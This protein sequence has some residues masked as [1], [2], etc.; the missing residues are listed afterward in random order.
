MEQKYGKYEV[1]RKIGQGGFGVVYEGRDPFIKRRVAIKTCSAEDEDMRRRFFREAEIVGTL[2]HR[3][4]VT[5]FDL[6]QQDGVPY[7]VQEYLT[8]EDLAHKIKRRDLIDDYT[9]LSYLVQVAEGLEY[10]HAQGVVH[11]DIKPAN[12]RILEDGSVKIMD[13]GIAKLASAETQLTHTGMAM[14]TAGYLPPEQIRGEKVDLRAD[15]FSYGVMS[16]ELLAGQRPFVAD[17]MSAVLFQIIGQEPAPLS[18]LWPQCPPALERLVRKSLAKNPSERYA[19]FTPLLADLRPLREQVRGHAAPVAPAPEMAT[20]VILSAQT[21]VELETLRGLEKR[22]REAVEKGDLTAAELEL[23][24]AKKRHGD[25]ATF[26]QV[27]DPLMARIAEIRKAWEEDRQRSER[28]AGLV[29]RART[30]R[31]EQNLGEA[32]LALTAA[33]D[34][35]PENQEVQSL[36]RTVDEAIEKKQYEARETEGARGAATKVEGLLREG[37][38]ERAEEALAEALHRHGGREPLPA[39]QKLVQ[40]AKVARRDAAVKDRLGRAQAQ[41]QAQRPAE[42]QEIL[43]EALQLHPENQEI[44][45]FLARVTAAVQKQ[46]DE[47]RRGRNAAAALARAEERQAA[48][49]ATVKVPTSPPPA[50]HH[51]PHPGSRPAVPTQSASWLGLWAGVGALV[52]VLVA[53]GG[54]WALKGRGGTPAPEPTPTAQISAEPTALP[55]SAPTPV[56]TPLPVAPGSGGLTLDALPW[57]EVVEIVD[58]SGKQWPLPANRFTPLFLTLPVGEYSVTLK[59]PG[60]G[61]AVTRKAL[62]KAAA[63]ESL[64]VELR[65]VNAEDYLRRV[66]F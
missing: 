49:E 2:Q 18:S 51:A 3:H 6:G 42:A 63:T 35:D 36:L 28:L 24:L 4:I 65:R 48:R 56:T 14:G 59:N 23:T 47:E 58:P 11:R 9:K 55:T 41:E 22:L 19:S 33:L 40:Q 25:S 37:Q 46:A 8:G 12:I 26:S 1:V 21:A 53:A 61:P 7:L 50:V 13:F 30:L 31:A 64:L 16:Y 57:A 27:M 60:A 15:I 38:L 52:A 20:Q 54:Y 34:L 32:R 44:K 29:E 39:V 45:K 17:N 66:G 43:R 10:A 62:V 5:V